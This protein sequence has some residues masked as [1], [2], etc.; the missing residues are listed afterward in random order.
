[1][2]PPVRIKLYGLFALT[3]RTYLT[4]VALGSVGLL[5]LLVAWFVTVTPENP[6]E[7]SGKYPMNPWYVWRVYA[8]WIIAGGLLLGWAEVYFVLK[9]FRRAEAEQQRAAAPEKTP[10]G[11]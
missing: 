10:E 7:K 8:P 4:W 5:A 2:Q 6:V 11:S 1:M 9:R 3:K